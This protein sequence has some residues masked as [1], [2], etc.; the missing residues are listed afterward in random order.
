MPVA[1]FAGEDYLESLGLHAVD[2]PKRAAR[3]RGKDRLVLYLA[4]TG[5]AP[6]PPAKQE[7]LLRD[8]AGLYYES[9]GSVTSGLR[10]VADALN[11]SL[12]DRNLRIS[13]SGRQGIGLFTQFVLR[14]DQVYLALSGP[15][16]AYLI[17]ETGVQNF[18]TADMESRGLG[19]SRTPPISFHQARLKTNDTLLFAAQPGSDWSAA[20]LAEMHGQGPQS[21]RR[22]LFSQITDV[23]AVL[24]QAR[25]GKGR[26]YLPRPLSVPPTPAPVIETKSDL[27]IAV[28]PPATTATQ[29]EVVRGM[30]EPGVKSAIDATQ[31]ETG[32]TVAAEPS[33]GQYPS[34]GGEISRDAV[35]TP[36]P[37]S[38]EV[39]AGAASPPSRGLDLS[40]LWKVLA[41]VGLP[42]LN[43]F[44][45][46]GKGISALFSRLI[47]EEISSTVMMLI[48]LAVPV[49]VVAVAMVVYNRLGVAAQF[50]QL[51]IQVEQMA[52]EAENQVEPQARRNSWGQLLLLLGEVEAYQQTPETQAL[53]Q[54]A[55]QVL[56]EL[57]LV[58]RID[59]QP[60][61][62]G[63]LPPEV[64]ITRM[65]V[66]EEDLYLLD[67]N[68]GNVIRAGPT[69]QGYA[70]FSTFQCGPGPVEL[71]EAGMLI[72]IV[73][74]PAVFEP[75]ASILALDDGG[76]VIYCSPGEAPLI[77]KLAVSSSQ[78]SDKAT[79]FTLD[80]SD[81]YV[82]DPSA[83]AVWIYWGS[84]VQ[85]EPSLFFD[86]EVPPLS[87]VI[88]L[89]ANNKELYLLHA[90]GYITLCY[91][92]TANVSPTRCSDPPYLDERSGL[93]GSPL[94]PP[95][96]FMQIL[97]TEPP[98]PSLYLLEP[99]SQAIY[100]FS[101][102]NLVYK[103]QFLPKEQ[104]SS[105]PA[106][107]FYLDAAKRM[108]YLAIG[109]EVYY[110]V[111]P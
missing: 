18:Y 50:D 66:A 107:A 48:A 19:Q 109:N 79:A 33:Q 13:N 83:N 90:D 77:D 43:A 95:S 76:N 59:Y 10:A 64:N 62:A 85:D 32:G 88:D 21:F 51:Y 103:R 24:I 1:R 80:L 68:S 40:G 25:P 94:V 65:V 102:R 86:Q 2:P 20:T 55:L 4:V 106:T 14:E 41:M 104:P 72:D 87:D 37:Q 7:R 84:D 110:G 105:Q 63:Q 39:G 99:E 100:H 57:D 93:E 75:E 98:D 5:N 45:R 22:K 69:D 58:K 61:I 54:R 16:H 71:S 31:A 42:L 34:V 101:L 23:N 56:D 78:S 96:P 70:L 53:R 3:G 26:F 27:D 8:L 81:L 38:P 44:Q 6:I 47:P 30:P 74:W 28:I 12:L 15:I 111:I 17:A 35:G 52:A 92:G 9:P 29:P 91:L 67:G 97:F 36:L 60:A 89:T 11:E 73:P 108:V 46:L 82:L 49:V